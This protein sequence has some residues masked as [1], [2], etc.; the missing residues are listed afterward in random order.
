MVQGPPADRL[1]L[2][3]DQ[4]SRVPSR[5]TRSTPVYVAGSELAAVARTVTV[6][7]PSAVSGAV[8]TPVKLPVMSVVLSA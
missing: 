2:V 8:Y 6:P 1:R 3:A 4:K 7:G 5:A